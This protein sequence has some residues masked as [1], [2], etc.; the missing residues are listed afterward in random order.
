MHKQQQH[1]GLPED[2]VMTSIVW[3][4]L[5][6]QVTM[7]VTALLHEALQNAVTSPCMLI[8]ISGDVLV[9]DD[10]LH[11][12]VILLALGMQYFSLDTCMYIYRSVN[13]NQKAL[14]FVIQI[15]NSTYGADALVVVQ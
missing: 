11:I 15:I 12:T 6:V 9:F 1:N 5:S 8:F 13:D 7:A 2:F 10:V 14:G 4:V 3:P